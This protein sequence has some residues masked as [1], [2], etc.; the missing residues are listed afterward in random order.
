MKRVGRVM[1]K[2]DGRLLVCFERPD[3]CQKCGACGLHG[4]KEML[5]AVEG[6]ADVGD[7]I[8]VAMPDAQVLKAST[9]AYLVPLC[10]LI[11]GLLVGQFA[12]GGSDIAMF[13]CG[14]GVMGVCWACLR[15]ADKRLQKKKRWQPYMVGKSD[16]TQK[17]SEGEP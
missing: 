1:D 13:L 4:R 11:V 7:E 16:P 12:F 2:E 6:E 8:T 10:G 15:Q 5:V 9:L 17:E 14:L 3:A